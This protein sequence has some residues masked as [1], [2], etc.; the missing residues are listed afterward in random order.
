MGKALWALTPRGAR[1]FHEFL[2]SPHQIRSDCE[3]PVLPASP[4][5]EVE[6]RVT[7]AVGGQP[8]GHP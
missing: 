7:K 8:G 6:D 1:V 5:R 3:V 4:A 2:S